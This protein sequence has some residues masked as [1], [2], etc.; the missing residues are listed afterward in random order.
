VSN[1]RPTLDSAATTIDELVKRVSSSAERFQSNGDEATAS[2]LYDVERS[3][4]AAG[5][6][7][8]LVV[9]RVDGA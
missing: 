2:D 1:D 5:R 3:L 8:S 9:G 7:L 4:R 6:R